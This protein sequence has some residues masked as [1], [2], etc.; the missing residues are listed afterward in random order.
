MSDI[1][2]YIPEDLTIPTDL[3]IK[4]D[5]N[6]DIYYKRIDSGFEF[7]VYDVNSDEEAMEIVREITDSMKREHDESQHGVSWRTVSMELVRSDWDFYKIVVWK[8]RVR[9]SY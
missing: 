6:I 4:I 3:R 7:R 1:K 9:D 2:F 8:Y 5:D